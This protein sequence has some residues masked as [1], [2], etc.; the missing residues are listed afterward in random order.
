MNEVKI[1]W[2]DD[3]IDLL[4]PHVMFLEQKGYRVTTVNNGADA[5]DRVDDEYFDIVFLDEN[6]P[7]LSGL[8]T[9]AKIKQSDSTLPVV[10]ITKSEEESIMEEA[11]GSKI[12]DYLIKPVNPHQI[13]LSLKKNLDEKRIRSEKTTSGYQ[14]QFREIGMKLMDRLDFHEWTELYKKLV[15]WGQEL[16]SSHDDAM[17][18]IFINQKSEANNQFSRFVRQNYLQWLNI[19]EDAPM[20]SHTVF[21]E[22]VLPFVKEESSSV[23]VLV[24]D[25]LRFDQW[26]AIKPRITE[27]YRV[28]SEDVFCS[29]LPTATHYAR[30]ALFAGM[31]PSEIEKRFPDLWL[32]EEDEGGK[33]MH[34][35]AFLE[36]NLRRLGYGEKWS[37]HKIT[38][39]N[40][41]KRLSETFHSLANNGLNVVVYNFVDMLSHARTEMEVIKELADNDAAYRSITQSWFDHSPL[42]E[43]VRKASEL[44]HRMVILT[45]HG[46]IRVET[47]VKVVGDRNTN[48]N[49]RYKAGRNL[50]YNAKEVFEVKNPSKAFLPRMNVSTSYVFAQQDGYF[51]YPNNYNHFVNFY[52]NTYQHGGISMEEMLIPLVTLQPK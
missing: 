20:M 29:I 45:D 42:F 33:N 31:M 44:G 48:T 4:R 46:T 8:E 32:N 49:L 51:V 11:I 18:E 10:M 14:Q 7:G 16:Q 38:N 1:L 37:Y 24:I 22:G 3:E 19:K 28:E 52:R 21:R 43:I 34:E 9:L 50:N 27:Y 23:L 5:V 30:N 39:L 13:L 41:G 40:A 47:P 35:E 25:N 15:F 26:K 6:M 36:A 2:A 17:A 12:S